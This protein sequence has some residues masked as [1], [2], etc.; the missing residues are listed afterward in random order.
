MVNTGLSEVIGSWKIIEMSL[1]RT[2][3]ISLLGEQQQVAP[4]ASCTAPATMRPGG[5]GISRIIDSA[6]MLLPQPDS[7][8][9]ASVSPD[10]TEKST[11]STA[12][13]MPWRV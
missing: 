7:P 2:P 8:T 3:R 12:L 6:V 9:I 11:S 4:S 5:S 13:T 10:A 1:P